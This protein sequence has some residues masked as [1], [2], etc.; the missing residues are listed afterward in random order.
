MKTLALAT[1]ILGTL[2]STAVAQDMPIIV[3]APKTVSASISDSNGVGSNYYNAIDQRTIKLKTQPAKTNI[4]K[5]ISN[6]NKNSNLEISSACDRSFFNSC[7]KS[8]CN[9]CACCE[10]FCYISLF[11]GWTVLEDM[12][13]LFTTSNPLNFNDGFMLGMSAGCS[14]CCGKG[15]IE[16]EGAWRNNSFE[17]LPDT[18][19]HIN[20]Y[21]TMFNIYRDFGRGRLNPYIGG[22]VGFALIKGDFTAPTPNATPHEIDS[23]AFAFQGIAGISL[24]QSERTALFTEYRFYGNT[25]VD[26]VDNTNT[27]VGDFT[28]LSHNLVFGIRIKR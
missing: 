26:I 23:F 4:E 8:D 11:G 22:G 12:T 17:P 19:G 21:A 20:N 15:R 5:S 2:V 7:C 3:A 16:I 10:T 1:A 9:P 25:P 13:E 14:I 27:D 6:A 28:Y 24:Q 18:F